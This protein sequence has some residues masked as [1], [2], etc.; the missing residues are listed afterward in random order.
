MA[1]LSSIVKNDRRFAIA[2]RL[3]EKRDAL[4]KIIKSVNVSDEEKALAVVKL[5]KMPRDSSFCRYKNRCMFTG[6]CRGVY[7]KFKLSRITFREMASK[8]EI[9]GIVK[10]SW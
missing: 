1:R 9:P 2:S 4:R 3:K 10:A 7:S 8:G 6:R 5:S